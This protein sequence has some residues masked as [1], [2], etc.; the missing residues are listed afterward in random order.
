MAGFNTI[1]EQYDGKV[2]KVQMRAFDGSPFYAVIGKDRADIR[3]GTWELDN[4]GRSNGTAIPPVAG[5]G[6][7]VHP[8]MIRVRNGNSPDAIRLQQEAGYYGI[9]DSRSDS[10]KTAFDFDVI[11]TKSVIIGFE[12]C[13]FDDKDGK[14]YAVPNTQEA[15]DDFV[16]KIPS[17]KSTV[18]PFCFSAKNFMRLEALTG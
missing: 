2:A 16:D 3:L 10:S 4:D 9:N 5:K 14:S 7:E 1:Q 6:K 17:I 8:C 15:I 11:V 13:Y 12:H 18:L